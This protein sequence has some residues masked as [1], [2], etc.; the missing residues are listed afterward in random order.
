MRVSSTQASVKA[1]WLTKVATANNAISSQLSG[2]SAFWGLAPLALNSMA[3]PSGTIMHGISTV[4]FF[5]LRCSPIIC[6]FDGLDVLAAFA[7]LTITKRSLRAAARYI[8][9]A[10]FNRVVSEADASPSSFAELQENPVFRI[11]LFVAAA[12]PQA[13]KLLAVSGVVWTKLWAFMFVGSFVII[14]VIVLQ[15]GRGWQDEKASK[16]DRAANIRETT[17]VKNI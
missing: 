3:Q 12:L 10:P 2:L 7:W 5:F 8:A 15:L 17:A 4:A 13:I 14:E 16:E 9:S 11:L 1:C 6:L